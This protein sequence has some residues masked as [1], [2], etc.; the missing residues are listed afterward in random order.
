M[1]KRGG[2][3]AEKRRNVQDFKEGLVC[4]DMLTPTGQS[5]E[6]YCSSLYSHS[7]GLQQGEVGNNKLKGCA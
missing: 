7:Q 3:L 2:S 5:G 6:I 4:P 1:M